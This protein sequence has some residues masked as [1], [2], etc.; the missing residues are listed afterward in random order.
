MDRLSRF[1]VAIVYGTAG[2]HWRPEREIE[3]LRNGLKQRDVKEPAVLPVKWKAANGRP[4]YNTVGGTAISGTL[5]TK[6][7]RQRRTT[8]Q[9]RMCRPLGHCRSMRA[10]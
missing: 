3:A 10:V 7:R 6:A 1:K 9:R 5:P 2:R 4:R 8:Q